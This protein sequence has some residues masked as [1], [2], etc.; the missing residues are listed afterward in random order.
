MLK[1]GSY[2]GVIDYK[3]A[4]TMLKKVVMAVLSLQISFFYLS[5]HRYDL[6]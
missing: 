5:L 6:V 4:I 1:I 2:G 3:S